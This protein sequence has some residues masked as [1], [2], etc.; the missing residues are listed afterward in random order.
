[1]RVEGPII[2]HALVAAG[3]SG[4]RLREGGIVFPLAKSYIS[5]EGKTLLY[6]NISGLLDVGI[7][8][9]VVAA[10]SKEKVQTAG[11]VLDDVLSGHSA[12]VVIFENPGFDTHHI[13]YS[14]RDKL[15]DCF[16]YTFGHQITERDHYMNMRRAK[17]SGNVVL[18]GFPN[19]NRSDHPVV[20]INPATRVMQKPSNITETN[21]VGSPFVF[22]QRWIDALPHQ[23]YLFRNMIPA[24]QRGEI[25]REVVVIPHRLPMEFDTREEYEIAMKAY[26]KHLNQNRDR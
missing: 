15:P 18:S 14:V 5:L 4:T 1:M 21:E 23:G 20:H 13:P 3:G 2:D 10:D 9:F 8:R 22:D 11:K 17:D 16:F 7:N 25:P 6:W 24:I 12:E 19:E 26:R